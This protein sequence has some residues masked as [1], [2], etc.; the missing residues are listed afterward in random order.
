M[1]DGNESV[2]LV[3]YEHSLHLNLDSSADHFEIRGE[4]ESQLQ[5]KSQTG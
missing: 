4:I 3:V 5:N 1:R 2:I